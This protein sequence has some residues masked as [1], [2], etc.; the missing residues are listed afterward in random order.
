LW[1]KT[2]GGDNYDWGRSV[3]QTTDGGYIITGSTWSFGAGY[4]DVY[5]IKTDSNGDRL[6]EKTFGGGSHDYGNSV[7]QTTDG[8]YIITGDT[9]S[10]SSGNIDVY[11]IKTDSNGDKLWEK[12]FGGDNHNLGESVQQTTD[13]GYIIT[14]FTSPSDAG[15][16]DVYLIKTDSNGDKL[17]EKTFGGDNSNWGRS[18]QQTTDGGYIITG[19]TSPSNTGGWDVYLIKTDSNGDK[20]WEK[21][22]GGNRLDWGESVRQTTDGGYIITGYTSSF[23]AGSYD[24]YLI[25]LSSS[26]SADA[27]PDQSVSSGEVVWFD[28]SNSYSSEGTIVSY[29]WS[30]KHGTIEMGTDEGPVVYYRFN[31][32]PNEATDYTV[33]LTIEDTIGRVSTD[34]KVITVTHLEKIA[35]VV[36]DD[37]LGTEF[38]RIGARASYNWVRSEGGRDIFK[39]SRIDLKSHY[40]V[41]A[42]VVSVEN[43]S[44]VLWQKRLPATP[45]DRTYYPENLYVHASDWLRVTAYG[46]TEKEMLGLISIVAGLLGLPTLPPGDVPFFYGSDMRYFAPDYID[47]SDF[48]AIDVEDTEILP[49]LMGR[50]CSPGELRIYDPQGR[51]TGL[52][53]GEVKEE[54]PDSVYFNGNFVIL[55]PSDPYRYE[56]VGTDAGTY[57]LGVIS[58]ET[59]EEI[60]ALSAANIPISSNSVHQYTADWEALS[61][62]RRELLLK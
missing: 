46:V 37:I 38:S 30:F 26:L 61:Q 17:W 27:G 11:L 41:G 28:A 39:I 13:G 42:Y 40:F 43:D 5:L 31:G 48:P 52:V 47:I 2:F 33:I 34:E 21:T 9:W 32:I 55:S 51:V 16:R 59:E 1:E 50:L 44:G 20:L 4:F 12:T 49:L 60:N 36:V 54:I 8:G 10:F 25:K 23:G 56:V 29:E 19:Y 6:W 45:F 58:V 53:N 15:S 24:V 35:E 18:V 7:Q 14:G 62:A 22:F 3:Q 57:G